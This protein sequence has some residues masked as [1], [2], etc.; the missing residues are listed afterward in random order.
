MPDTLAFDAAVSCLPRADADIRTTAVLRRC[1]IEDVRNKP[2]W[3]SPYATI[4]PMDCR[5]NAVRG[6]SAQ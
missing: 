6:L 3:R 2:P 4:D 1:V 5:K